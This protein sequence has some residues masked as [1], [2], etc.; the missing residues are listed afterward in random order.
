MKNVILF[1]FILGILTSCSNNNDNNPEDSQLIGV[2]ER[3]YNVEIGEI[4]SI[5]NEGYEYVGQYTFN[6]D[7]TFELA[8]FIRN[9]DS[10]D[11]LAYSQRYLGI[12]EIDGN[13]LNFINDYWGAEPLDDQY[14]DLKSI[15]ELTLIYEEETWG[16]SYSISLNKE[17]LIDFDPCGPLENCV[18]KVTFF[19]IH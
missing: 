8:S 7:Q 9:I 18:D 13:R 4:P 3:S 5:Q 19:R 16:F 6:P 2:W 12:Y 17:L 14:S 15:D 11:I 10:G 1:L